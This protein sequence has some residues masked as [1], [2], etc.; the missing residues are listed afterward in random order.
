M[1]HG[2]PR[3]AP[4]AAW[5][6]PCNLHV[7]ASLGLVV[8]ALL[9]SAEEVCAQNNEGA[10]LGESLRHISSERYAELYVQPLTG[11]SGAALSSSLFTRAPV[12]A[13]LVDG[14]DIYLGVR[15][16]AARSQERKFSAELSETRRV[17]HEGKI[18]TA[19]VTYRVEDRPTAL[20]VEES[21]PIQ[22]TAR[23]TDE[24]GERVK[25][26]VSFEAPP[27]L[28]GEGDTFSEF[29]PTAVLQGGI[30]V[31]A[32]GTQL[33]VR[34]MPE[35]FLPNRA[36]RRIGDAR[37]IGG[38]LRHTVTRWISGIPFDIAA[39]GFYQE[40][41]ASQGSASEDYARL[42]VWTTGLTLSKTIAAIT[43]HAGGG[44]GRTRTHVNY[45]PDRSGEP[46]PVPVSFSTGGKWQFRGRVGAELVVGPFGISLSY[47]NH[48]GRS[49]LSAGAGIVL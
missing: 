15:A 24:S 39:H 44:M 16:A 41:S 6:Y 11:A 40:V 38:G 4:R 43:F 7:P 13:G 42:E 26:Q 30:G 27:G 34:Y 49:V 25:K 2:C 45:V 47:N 21:A 32:I 12:N 10:A 46:A 5:L 23:F 33:S 14:V 28:L 22:G 48:A 3:D 18:Y 36:S 17:K 29:S 8:V 37:L 19:E 20:G 35:S 1:E 31:Q 9:F